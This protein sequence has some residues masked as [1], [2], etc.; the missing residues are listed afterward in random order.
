[1]LENCFLH[2]NNSKIRNNWITFDYVICGSVRLKKGTNLNIFNQLNNLFHLL[3][4]N[5]NTSDTSENK[6]P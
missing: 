4:S 6:L 5:R 3:G 2:M 1:M